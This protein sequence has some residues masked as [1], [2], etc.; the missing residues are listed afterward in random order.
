MTPERPI[1]NFWSMS[2]LPQTARL[3]KALWEN[4]A[5]AARC[6]SIATLAHI[7][8]HTVSPQDFTSIHDFRARLQLVPMPV[9]REELFPE[10][11]RDA[12][13]T[14]LREIAGLGA[15]SPAILWFARSEVLGGLRVSRTP[16]AEVVLDLL[17]WDQSTVWVYDASDNL[18]VGVDRDE[19]CLEPDALFQLVYGVTT[20]S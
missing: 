8:G 4:S 5:R 14:R 9:L 3:Q 20:P 13:L 18:L 6:E 16:T 7:L 11:G 15:P 2:A 19:D 17:D 1:Q 12:V 10:S